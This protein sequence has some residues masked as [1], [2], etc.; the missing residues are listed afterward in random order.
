MGY[1]CVNSTATILYLNEPDVKEALHVPF[2]LP[3]IEEW[4]MCTR[5]ADL[6]EKWINLMFNYSYSN[7]N[8]DYEL[9]SVDMTNNFLKVLSK[10]KLGTDRQTD[11]LFTYPI[12]QN[13]RVLM[14]YGEEDIICNFLGGRWFA[15]SLKQEVFIW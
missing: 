15:E 12:L 10:V 14:F 6:L 3:G 9:K 13:K 2:A 1:P 5:Y 4:F 8:Y 11:T 7:I